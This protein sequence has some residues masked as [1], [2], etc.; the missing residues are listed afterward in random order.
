MFPSAEKNVVGNATEAYFCKMR[1]LT[2]HLLHSVFLVPL[3]DCLSL[4]I[5]IPLVCLTL[6]RRRNNLRIENMSI[7]VLSNVF[8]I[9]HR[10]REQ[11]VP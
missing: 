3:F 2:A 11:L 5:N 8:L 4:I 7:T 6:F 1:A 9:T 10:E